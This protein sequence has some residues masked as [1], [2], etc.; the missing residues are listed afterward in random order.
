MDLVL[1]NARL[2]DGRSVDV[3][4]A[5][6]VIVSVADALP[7]PGSAQG[8]GTGTV[9]APTSVVDCAGRVLIPGLIEAHLHVDKALL[10][11]ERPNPDGTLAG[12]I[13]VTGELKRGFT[14]ATVRDR[15]RTLLDQAITNGT[16]LVRAH[17]DVD[18]IVGLT[19]VEVLLD[20]RDEYRDALDLQIVAF[21]QEGIAKAPGTLALLRQ[22]L[23]AG[24]DV[25][26]GCTYNEHTLAACHEH[27]ETVLDL[28]EE[29]GVPADLHADFAD[30]TSDPRYA[31]AGHI[32]DR[33]T[34]RGLQ[35]RVALGHVTS[36]A[37]LPRGERR[38]LFDRLAAAG[39]A[40]VPLP[41]TDLHLGGRSDD[42]DVRR[43]VVP[44]RELWDAG[45]TSAYASNNVRNAFTPF[46]NADLLDVGLLLA[47]TGHLSGP[48]DLRRVLAMATTGA[49]EVVG[50][51]DTHGIRPG[52]AADLVVLSTTDPDGVLLDRPDRALVV[53]RGR[54]VAETTRTTRL[55]TTRT[56]NRS[57]ELSHA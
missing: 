52:A 25:I 48:D 2:T 53:K 24:A 39:V 21:P 28:A 37:S 35:G 49:A 54:V 23:A 10:D 3:T 16:T 40:V 57:K 22:A 5:D 45:I 1:T 27:V 51:A 56:T 9:A 29:F 41:A 43:G 6:G 14:H 46:G 8:I 18:P 44:V 26:G 12:A 31:L 42:H 7:G 47:Q 38:V 36:V 34:A 55:T 15:A 17:P 13:A 20:L 32:A 30:D 4:I 33:V 50:V 11:R 19:G